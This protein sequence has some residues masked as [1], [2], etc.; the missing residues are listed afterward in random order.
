MLEF[1]ILATDV[2]IIRELSLSLS[3]SQPVC[4]L[5]KKPITQLDVNLIDL[6]RSLTRPTNQVPLGREGEVVDKSV[7]VERPRP[8]CN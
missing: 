1:S 6:F 2:I 7:L 4:Q 3:L 8:T 5:N